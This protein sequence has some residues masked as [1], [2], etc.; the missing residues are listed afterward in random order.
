MKQQI[1]HTNTIGTTIAAITLDDSVELSP[2]LL[3]LVAK[4]GAMD[5]LSVGGDEGAGEGS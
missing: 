5:G 4:E 1:R 3:V 2:L